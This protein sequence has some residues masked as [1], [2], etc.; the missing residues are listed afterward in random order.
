VDDKLKGL[1]PFLP[2]NLP[3]TPPQNRPAA[4]PATPATPSQ[5]ASR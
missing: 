5:G 4:T 2:L 1:V 3:N